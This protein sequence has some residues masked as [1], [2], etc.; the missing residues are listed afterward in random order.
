MPIPLG[1]LAVA[2]AGA[3]SLANSYDLL[4]TVSITGGSTTSVS[5]SGLGSFSAYKHLQ[6]RYA[7]SFSS[8][9]DSR[10]LIMRF[11]GDSGANYAWHLLQ[12]EGSGT[13]QTFR[14]T[15][16]SYITASEVMAQPRTS[17]F[18]SGVIDLLDF[19]SPNK[20][21]TSRSLWGIVDV[22]SP[23]RRIGLYSGFWNN[24]AAVTSISL[25]ADNSAVFVVG[26]RF[27]LY[28]IK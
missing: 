2:G 12:G 10:Y 5:F 15:S 1:V 8:G 9:N 13:A 19:S 20:N 14:Y 21:T 24:T 17:Q 22:T 18:S 11:N 28:G 27:S 16:Q 4:Q 7:A 6:I 3:G 23:Y 25:A 26:S